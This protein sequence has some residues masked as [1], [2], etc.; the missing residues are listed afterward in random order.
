MSVNNADIYKYLKTVW[1]GSDL[2][3]LFQALWKSGSSTSEFTVLC[4]QEAPA[5]QPFPY[6]VM[7]PISPLT[8]DS[9]SGSGNSIREIR[10]ITIMFNVFARDVSGD[11]RSSKE[12]AA[13]LAEEIMKIFGGHPTENPSDLTTST[14]LD[15]GNMLIIQCERDYGLHAGSD[16]YQWLL[17]YT[18][19]A[20]VPVAI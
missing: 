12:I 3:T 2:D 17:E 1:D 15:N 9:M 19:K 13:Y 5:K 16:E 18:F 7:D 8:T 4:D 14:T 11:S 6:C 10:D 20:D